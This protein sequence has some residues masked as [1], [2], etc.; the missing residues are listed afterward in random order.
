MEYRYSPAFSLVKAPRLTFIFFSAVCLV[1]RVVDLSG[2]DRGA[3]DRGAIFGYRG[4]NAKLPI[5]GEELAGATA[6][7]IDVAV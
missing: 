1:D 6:I 2:C 4:P 5:G 3:R 7:G